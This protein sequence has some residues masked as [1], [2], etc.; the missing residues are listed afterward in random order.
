MRIRQALPIIFVAGIALVL[1]AIAVSASSEPRRTSGETG[2]LI[3][4]LPAG[5]AALG[6][7][8][9]L[10]PNASATNLT[11]DPGPASPTAVVFALAPP[12][13]P[14]PVPASAPPATAVPS[15]PTPSPVPPTALPAGPT[16][17]AT[18]S[19]TA[20]ASRTATP[21][22]TPTG[23]AA[24]AGQPS[25]PIVTATPNR[26]CPTP[27]PA[28]VALPPGTSADQ[29]ALFDQVQRTNYQACLRLF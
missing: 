2:A 9:V 20:A 5:P 19:P 16:I 11:P 23:Q 27:V 28:E 4:T 14:T 13:T 26:F 3:V 17:V 1:V 8:T 7:P 22:R 6:V 29:R 10:G 24:V 15:A 21:V 25:T 18:A 12:A